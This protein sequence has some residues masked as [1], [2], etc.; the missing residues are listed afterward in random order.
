MEG[1]TTRRRNDSHSTEFGLWIRD[2]KELDSRQSGFTANNIDFIIRNYKTYRWMILEEKR[3]MSDATYSQWQAMRTIHKAAINDANYVGT[4][5]L[6]F[7]KTC[8]TDS[9]IILLNRKR[10]L[11]IDELIY[12]LSMQWVKEGYKARIF[13]QPIP[14][15]EHHAAPVCPGAALSASK[16]TRSTSPLPASGL[17]KS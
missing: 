6:Q 7:S 8:P 11:T 16:K 5:L 12:F 17:S 3:F 1:V 4:F 2:V 14:K 10:N 15:R 9:D 13:A